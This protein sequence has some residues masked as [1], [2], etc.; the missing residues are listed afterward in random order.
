MADEYD[1]GKAF[2]AIEKELMASMI[3]NMQNHKVEEVNEQRQWAMWQV[4]QLKAL[5]GYKRKNKEVYGKKFQDI[6]KQIDEL[7][8]MAKVEGEMNQETAILRAIKRGSPARRVPPGASAEFFRLNERKLEALLTATQN[9]MQKAETA[10]LR[11][12]NDR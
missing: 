6:N 7:I 3:R 5:E 9:D 2:A 10:I 8:R 4:E 12:S 1:V 11:M